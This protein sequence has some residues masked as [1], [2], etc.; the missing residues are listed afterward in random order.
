MRL[1]F[2]KA[3]VIPSVY[4]VFGYLS[5]FIL[6]SLRARSRQSE[7]G[8]APRKKKFSG[9]KQKKGNVRSDKGQSRGKGKKSK[10]RAR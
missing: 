2:T 3:S 7:E 6:S 5:L 1:N 10:P 4:E 9:K 8:E